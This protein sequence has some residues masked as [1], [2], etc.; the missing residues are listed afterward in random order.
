MRIKFFLLVLLLTLA[1]T[2]C[3]LVGGQAEQGEQTEQTKQTGKEKQDK[4]A[5][6]G[7]ILV[8][9]PVAGQSSNPVRTPEDHGNNINGINNALDMLIDGL[10]L[11]DL[12]NISSCLYG[13]EE[14]NSPLSLEE[15]QR[16]VAQLHPMQWSVTSYRPVGESGA[17]VAVSYTMPDG[18]MRETD[19]F[20]MQKEG[21]LWVAHYN[22]FAQ[23]FHNM[24]RHLIKNQNDSAAATSSKSVLEDN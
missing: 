1:C 19:P 13:L 5:A 6:A 23:S 12:K 20:N 17:L 16:E 9:D 21:T 14:G 7:D 11:N 10:V 8:V 22:S 4:G 2:G 15:L 3:G 18:T 24:A